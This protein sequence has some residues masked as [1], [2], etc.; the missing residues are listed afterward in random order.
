MITVA[1]TLQLEELQRQ[2]RQEEARGILQRVERQDRRQRMLQDWRW[3]A[4]DVARGTA[5]VALLATMIA[6]AF[7]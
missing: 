5:M 1:E 6:L 4:W 7:N 3:W 2:G